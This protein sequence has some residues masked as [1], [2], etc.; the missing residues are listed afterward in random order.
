MTPQ[1]G[2]AAPGRTWRKFVAPGLLIA[3]A[4]WTLAWLAPQPGEPMFMVVVAVAALGYLWAL[5]RLTANAVLSRRGLLVCFAF[6]LAWRVPLLTLPEAPAHDAVRYLWDA[7]VVS[8]G[9]S[10]YAARPDDAALDELHSEVTRTVDAAW[11]PTIY[12]PAAQLYFQLVTGVHESI[13]AFRVAALLIDAAIMAVLAWVLWT[14]GRPVGWA[15]LYAWHPLIPLEGVSGAH[16]DFAGVLILLL[17]WLALLHRR[18]TVA[19][20]AFAAAVMVKPLPLVLAPLYWRRIRLRDAVLAALAA[21]AVAVWIA[22]GSL[23]LG[24]TGAF[25]DTFRF[26]GPLFTALE[27]VLPPRVIAAGAVGI[28][29]IAAVW[30]RRTRDVSDPE[31]WVW[32][33]ALAL[34]ASPV[35]YPWYLVWLIPF[36]IGRPAIPI[37]LWTLSVLVIYPAWHFRSPG[38][39]LT[40]TPPLLLVQFIVPAAAAV[41]IAIRRRSHSILAG[42]AH[43]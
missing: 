32:P 31:A 1:P 15:L 39:P 9:M 34:V 14:I 38:N 28:G 4:F 16:L 29:L 22:R 43:G 19:V 27:I 26:N 10:P 5:A 12:P 40:V 3:S 6:A 25:M 21:V 37:R 18:T 13:V 35:I 33:M 23:P 36:A 11:L 24:S 41:I 2:H 7:R 8:A 30:L 17:S 20:L 42:P